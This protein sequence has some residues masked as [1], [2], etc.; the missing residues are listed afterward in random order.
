MLTPKYTRTTITLPEELLWQIKKRALKE[1]RAFKEVVIEGLS[2]YF[3]NS[4]KYAKPESS[5][6][7]VGSLFGAWGKGEKGVDFVKRR[8]YG[9]EEKAREIYLKK[10][11][12]KS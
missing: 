5:D 1:K 2:F 9:K 10:A 6:D 4:R 3:I 7:W 12:R 8:R 11:W